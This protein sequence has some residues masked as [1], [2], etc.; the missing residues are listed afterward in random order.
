ME[1]KEIVE[2]ARPEEPQIINLME[3]LKASIANARGGSSEAPRGDAK[4]DVLDPPKK[5]RAKKASED[6][7]AKMAPSATERRGARKKKSG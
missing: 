7:P 4:I 2:V 6:A 3:A 1:G 5:G